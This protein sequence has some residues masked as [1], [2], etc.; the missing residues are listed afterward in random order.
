MFI[1]ISE[2]T[3]LDLLAA[4]ASRAEDRAALLLDVVHQIR[5]EQDDRP[6]AVLQQPLVAV[7]DP[8]IA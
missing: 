7:L 6:R 8:L 3:I 5:V 2:S 1:F 4:A